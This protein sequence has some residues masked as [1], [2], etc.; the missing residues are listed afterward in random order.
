MADPS[1]HLEFSVLGQLEI[2]RSG[3]ALPL[4]GPRQRTLLAYLLLRRNEVVP[5]ERLIDAVWGETPP[6]SAPN[7]L[8]VAVHGVRKLL[9]PD[10]LGSDPAGYELSVR[11]GELDLDTFERVA[12]RARTGSATPTELRDALALWRGTAASDAFPDGVRS[13]LARLDELRTFVLEERIEADLASG[14][15]GALVEEL[16]ALVAEHPYRERLHGQLLVALYRSGRQADALD[17]Y[18]RA[19][20][21]FVDDLG[22]DPGLGLRDLEARILRQD[23]DLDP[24]APRPALHGSGAPLLRYRKKDLRAAGV[25]RVLER[26]IGVSDG[27]P[28]LEGGRVLNV[29]NVVWCTGFRPDLSWID[30]PYEREDDGYPSQYRGVVESAPGL[31]FV[32]LLFLHSFASML[33]RGMCRDAERVAMHIAARPTTHRSG[34][35]ARPVAEQ[36]AS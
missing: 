23:P 27:G 5:R 15:H 32:G 11:P 8:Q 22:L 33:I 36:V 3:A 1:E 25:E 12:E 6:A 20:R 30:V 31:Y 9:G 10:R 14:R 4:G 7:A 16:E 28:V 29:Q 35:V 34:G 2:R 21:M 13:M 18:A 26:T 17:A 24:P 19:R